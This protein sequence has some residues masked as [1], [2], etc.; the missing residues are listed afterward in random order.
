MRNAIKETEGLVFEYPVE[1]RVHSRDNHIYTAF[2]LR[3]PFGE[4]EAETKKRLEVTRLKYVLLYKNRTISDGSHAWLE[5]KGTDTTDLGFMTK[6]LLSKEGAEVLVQDVSG[7]RFTD[8]KFENLNNKF[9]DSIQMAFD[10]HDLLSKPDQNIR[11][12]YYVSRWMGKDSGIVDYRYLFGEKL[13]QKIEAVFEPLWDIKMSGVC[14]T[15]ISFPL[16]SLNKAVDPDVAAEL[17]SDIL[18]TIPRMVDMVELVGQDIARPGTDRLFMQTKVR[19]T[20][21]FYLYGIT[22]KDFPQLWW[23]EYDEAINGDEHLKIIENVKSLMDLG[24]EYEFLL[25]E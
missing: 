4:Q 5:G 22:L 15:G 23:P 7:I 21:Y 8:T 12:G 2:S 11:L 10:L 19:T 13:S 9:E 6:A 25:E 3:P 20:N 17:I 16:Y 14:S 1:Q 24:D 18:K